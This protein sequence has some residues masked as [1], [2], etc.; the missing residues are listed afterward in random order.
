MIKGDIFG[1]PRVFGSRSCVTI[2]RCI[3]QSMILRQVHSIRLWAVS[4]A[5]HD[6][7]SL[8]ILRPVQLERLS[9]RSIHLGQPHPVRR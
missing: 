9:G 3:E 6:G 4:F 8:P 7:G 2:G 5:G 1:C